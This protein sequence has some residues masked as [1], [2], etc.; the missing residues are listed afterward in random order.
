MP[1]DVSPDRDL[2]WYQSQWNELCNLLSVSDPDAVVD[3]VRQ[4]QGR[5]DAL[6]QHHQALV[7]GGVEDP[8]KARE[9]IENMADQLEE[10]YAERDRRA[11]T[12]VERS[13][14]AEAPSGNA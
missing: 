12:Y 1:P 2:A 5:V 14:D 4:L 11:E 3:A 7:E 10:L 9:M 8:E 13:G 6:S